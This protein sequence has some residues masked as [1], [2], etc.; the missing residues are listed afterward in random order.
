MRFLCVFFKELKGQFNCVNVNLE[1]P[2]SPLFDNSVTLG[3][4][5]NINSISLPGEAHFSHFFFADR[6]DLILLCP[7][8]L[9]C[10]VHAAGATVVCRRVPDF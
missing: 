5:R 3:D 10:H 4:I 1:Q 2:H 9:I 8:W 6:G 7:S